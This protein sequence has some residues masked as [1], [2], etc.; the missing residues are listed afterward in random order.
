MK[1]ISLIHRNA[2]RS[3]SLLPRPGSTTT[4]VAASGG[5]RRCISTY[6]PA[7]I[8][9]LL[10]YSTTTYSEGKSTDFG[11]EQLTV[12]GYIRSVRKQK[13]VAFAA[14]GDG[15]TLKTVQAVL[16]PQL[17]EGSVSSPHVNCNTGRC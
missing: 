14:I 1:H 7:S 4:S 17:A 3:I 10:S 9:E 2:N 13:R 12:N 5:R 16:S 8:S 6:S 15:S 11:G